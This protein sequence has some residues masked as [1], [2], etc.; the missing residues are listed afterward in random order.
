MRLKRASIDMLFTVGGLAMIALFLPAPQ[1]PPE[2]PVAAAPVEVAVHETTKP[3]PPV[4]VLPSVPARPSR[5]QLVDPLF[6][7][8]PEARNR[9]TNMELLMASA[10]MDLKRPAPTSKYKWCPPR[11]GAI[12]VSTRCHFGAND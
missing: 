3:A 2:P 11:D 9:A 4:A 12:Y 8:G 7:S 5:A 1:K 6:S 10:D